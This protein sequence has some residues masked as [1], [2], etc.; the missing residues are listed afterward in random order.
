MNE[1]TPN[2]TRH[3]LALAGVL[4]ATVFTG[5][6]AILGIQHTSA[7]TRAAAPASMVQVA[8]PQQ[9]FEEND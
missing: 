3:A 7:Q 2:S 8:Q 1:K 9:H 6:A 4:A 5:G